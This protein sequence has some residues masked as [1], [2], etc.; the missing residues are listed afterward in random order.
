MALKM[1][2]FSANG[3]SQRAL[4][5][6]HLYVHSFHSVVSVHLSVL[7]NYLKNLEHVLEYNYH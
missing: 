2:A 6:G 7:T 5:L 3:M 1:H 4:N